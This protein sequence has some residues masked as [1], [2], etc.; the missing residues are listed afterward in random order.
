MQRLIQFLIMITFVTALSSLFISSI[1][2]IPP[3]DL[4]RLR[5][6]NSLQHPLRIPVVARD[7]IPNTL[8]PPTTTTLPPDASDISP[9][10][11]KSPTPDPTPSPT[12]LLQDN[13]SRSKQTRAVDR[14]VA[15]AMLRLTEQPQSQ[16]RSAQR[17]SNKLH[18][19]NSVSPSAEHRVPIDNNNRLLNNDNAQ[20]GSKPFVIADNENDP[21]GSIMHDA[22][23]N[24]ADRRN[25]RKIPRKH[26]IS[27]RTSFIENDQSERAMTNVA[28]KM[29]RIQNVADSERTSVPK[30]NVISNSANRI[31]K[32]V[33]NIRP[34]QD[35]SKTLPNTLEEA[36]AKLAKQ[37]SEKAIQSLDNDNDE[38]DNQTV[39][40]ENDDDDDD[41]DEH[42][43]A[44]V[45]RK[46][47]AQQRHSIKDSVAA[48]VAGNI[49]RP[50][51]T[52]NVATKSEKR[53]TEI[54]MNKPDAVSTSS[55][56][57]RKAESREAGSASRKSSGQGEMMHDEATKGTGDNDI[58]GDENEDL[59]DDDEWEQAMDSA[60]RTMQRGAGQ[61]I[62]SGAKRS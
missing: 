34:E 9:D 42:F 10:L 55:K 61:Q 47:A 2:Y 6:A 14:A 13:D 51:E 24:L 1:L 35:Y 29:Q 21:D 50:D 37:L 59:M 7:L 28:N 16:Q 17:A 57:G 48:N 54:Q 4:E 27:D 44:E 40:D 58:E 38:T 31:T 62:S 36:T 49:G 41:S 25:K 39:N 3:R 15:Q 8:Q 45:M 30:S 11:A 56:V 5:K 53:P 32:P 46:L 18:S 43:M 19:M 26:D 20:A 22:M 23:L 60:L 52:V 12:P 33:V